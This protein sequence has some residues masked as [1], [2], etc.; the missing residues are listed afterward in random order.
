VSKRVQTLYLEV[1]DDLE[2]ITDFMSAQGAEQ[3]LDPVQW[4]RA[5]RD[6]IVAL[7]R[8][9]VPLSKTTRRE[10]ADELERLYRPTQESRKDERR[11][12]A[13]AQAVAIDS[14]VATMAYE[15]KR[16]GVRAPVK[17]AEEK[18]AQRYGF[19]S[20]KALNKFIRRRRWG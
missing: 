3:C 17:Q 8:S 13:H 11:S 18:L 2:F 14:E 15:L 7:L 4:E 12:L 9:K 16:Q 6:A 19:A 5:R 1:E 20:G 10:L